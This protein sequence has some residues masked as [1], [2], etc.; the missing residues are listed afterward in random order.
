MSVVLGFG[1][2]SGNGLVIERV[3]GKIMMPTI[4]KKNKTLFAPRRIK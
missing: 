3:T 4:G 1:T 2:A